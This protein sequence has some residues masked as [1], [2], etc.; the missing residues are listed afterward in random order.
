MSYEGSSGPLWGDFY[1]C[2]SINSSPLLE[3]WEQGA[4]EGLP[5]KG[6]PACARTCVAH[7]Q[8]GKCDCTALLSEQQLRK[9]C[10]LCWDWARAGGLQELRFKTNDLLFTLKILSLL[11]S[12]YFDSLSPFVLEGSVVPNLTSGVI[13]LPT[14]LQ[15]ALGC[16]DGFG[17]LLSLKSDS[18]ERVDAT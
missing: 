12:I 14:V 9:R 5:Y 15:T 10:A 8:P 7:G 16:N 18:Y 3:H 2:S 17:P 13:E 11:Q 1:Q 4:V 6:A